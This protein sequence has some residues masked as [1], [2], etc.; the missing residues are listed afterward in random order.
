MTTA[1]HHKHSAIDSPARRLE[2]TMAAVRVAFT[3]LGTRKTLTQ[4]Q[5]AQ[6]AETFQAEGQYLSAAKKLL[7][8][9]H[10]SFR[11]VTAVKNCITSYWKTVTLPFPEAGI[12]LIRQ[13]KL[14]IFDHQLQ[15]MREQLHSAVEKLERALPQLQQTARDRL[16]SLYNMADYPDNLDGLFAVEWSF[17]SVQPPDYLLQLNPEL[18][19]K[20]HRRMQAR[21]EEAVTLAEQA[22]AEEFGKLIGH[23]TERLSDTG[24]D[25]QPKIFR[26]SAVQNL[27][28]FFDRFRQLNVRSNPELDRLVDSAQQAIGGVR[29]QALRDDQ[30]LRRRIAGELS[31]VAKSLDG[32]VIDQPRRRIL[33]NP[34]PAEAVA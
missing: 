12:R 19:E 28:D 14:D 10:P 6:A 29:P 8:T 22:F 24:P 26:D 16:G 7:D 21:F 4:D 13:D 18:Y 1:T 11:A 23:I 2:T 32:L 27:R 15:D 33:R 30:A 17:P 31:S 5:K 25:G 3:W 9:S 20:E 34:S